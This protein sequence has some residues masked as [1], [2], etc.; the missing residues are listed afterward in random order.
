LLRNNDLTGRLGQKG[1]CL[2]EEWGR[3]WR[4]SQGYALPRRWLRRSRDHP[5]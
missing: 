1:R 5:R 3:C 2:L 4:R